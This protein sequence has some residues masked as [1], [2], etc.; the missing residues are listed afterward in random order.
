MALYYEISILPTACWFTYLLEM[1]YRKETQYFICVV[2][3]VYMCLSLYL[4]GPVYAPVGR[5]W[6]NAVFNLA[7]LQLIPPRE[8]FY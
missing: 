4:S 6:P 2:H 3:F 8:Q 5:S 7:L 1:E